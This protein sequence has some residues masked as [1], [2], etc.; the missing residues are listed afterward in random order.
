V[1]VLGKWGLG[2][3]RW[4]GWGGILWRQDGLEVVLTRGTQ[5]LA[6]HLLHTC[7]ESN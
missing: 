1:C 6:P 7:V 2:W 5:D 4:V 3:G